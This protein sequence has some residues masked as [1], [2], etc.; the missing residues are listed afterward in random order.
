MGTEIGPINRLVIAAG[1]GEGKTSLIRPIL[2]GYRIGGHVFDHMNA[3]PDLGDRWARHAEFNPAPE[4]KELKG[5]DNSDY[6]DYA[7]VLDSIE[8][9][10][11]AAFDEGA[12]YI[13]SG[14]SREHL[15]Y[16]FLNYAR[17]HGQ[18]FVVADKRVTGMSVLLPDCASHI[19]VRPGPRANVIQ[20]LRNCGVNV[21]ELEPLGESL[22]P[23]L[24]NP[25]YLISNKDI[26]IVTA[27]D[28]VAGMLDESNF[29]K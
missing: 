7:D 19:A 22:A 21:R 13:P 12:S 2:Q 27:R 14:C 29:F 1:A 15:T 3:F 8:T 4:F 5:A 26:E 16:Q 23:S 25:W 28:I 11:L 9:G 24:D 10:D 6:D 20:W 17:N 18:K